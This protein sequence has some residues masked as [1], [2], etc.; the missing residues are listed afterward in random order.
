M[1]LFKEHKEE[2]DILCYTRLPQDEL[3]YAPKLAYSMHLAYRNDEDHFQELN[4][5]S[6]VLFAKATENDSGSLNAELEKSVS[7]RF[8]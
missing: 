8:G 1:S 6:G 4:H 5:N 3:I 2:I 7:F